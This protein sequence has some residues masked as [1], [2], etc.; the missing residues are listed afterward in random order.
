MSILGGLAM[1]LGKGLAANREL[2]QEQEAQA[3]LERRERS[4]KM[5]ED[6]YLQVQKQVAAKYANSPME[7][8]M[9]DAG[10]LSPKE[11]VELKMQ[12]DAAAN[13]PVKRDVIKGVDGRNY[14]QD[15]GEPVLPNV[16]AP[17]E[18]PTSAI[19][20]YEYGLTNPEFVEDQLKQKKAGAMN[21][22]IGGSDKFQETADKR[23]A[24]MFS[25]VS[26]QGFAAKRSSIQI[27]RLSSLLDSV[28]TGSGAALQNY[29][30]NLGIN[31][32]GLDDIQAASAII[33]QLVPS[34]RPPGSGTMSDADLALFKQSLPRLINSPGGNQKIIEVMKGIAQYDIQLGEISQ[35]VLQGNITP[36]EGLDLMAKVAN[37]LADIGGGNNVNNP[38]EDLD[39]DG[40]LDQY[41]D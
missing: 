1:G 24:E 20:N 14:Y 41:A 29:A 18:K 39:I 32:E 19:Q 9:L 27:D 12:R 21:L 37:P 5:K 8:E 30:G 40:L 6:A 2:I 4:K 11:I 17:Q 25:D 7:V 31:T 22:S 13:T 15:T 10:V 36:N 28:G 26:D 33:S 35:A 34:Q 23:A 16:E 3:E 38:P